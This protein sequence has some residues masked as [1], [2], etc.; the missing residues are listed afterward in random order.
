VDDV[1]IPDVLRQFDPFKPCQGLFDPIG[2]VVS[3][4]SKTLTHI[5]NHERYI[6]A[7]RFGWLDGGRF[8]AAT[9]EQ[10]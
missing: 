4:Q 2:S 10:K 1:A 8:L 7:F 6:L 9:K 3:Q 5:L